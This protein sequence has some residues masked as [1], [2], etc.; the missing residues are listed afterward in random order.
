MHNKATQGAGGR[1]S[2]R[3]YC[4]RPAYFRSLRTH[5]C[6]RARNRESALAQQEGSRCGVVIPF[7]LVELLQEPVDIGHL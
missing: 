1:P 3:T 5:N 2:I 6:D 7:E 4:D